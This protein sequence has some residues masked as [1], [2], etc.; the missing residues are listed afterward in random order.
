[1]KAAKCS[2]LIV[3]A[4]YLMISRRCEMKIL[5]ILGKRG[6]VTIPFEIRETVG[7]SYN[8]VLSFTVEDEN[9]VTIKKERICD[10]NCPKYNLSLTDMRDD[11]LLRDFIDRLPSSKQREVLVHLS[12]KWAAKN[13]GVVN[14]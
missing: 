3:R 8:D 10:N 13:G 2:V 14:A 9:T 1:V 5:R 7:F 4:A 12:L 6:R 11:K